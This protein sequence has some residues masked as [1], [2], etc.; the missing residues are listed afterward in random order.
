MKIRPIVTVYLSSKVP[1]GSNIGEIAFEL[2]SKLAKNY[3]IYFGGRTVGCM[4]KL[5]EGAL[6]ENGII[7]GVVPNKLRLPEAEPFPCIYIDDDIS[8]EGHPLLKRKQRMFSIADAYIACSGGLGTLD[9]LSEV[10][11][12]HQLKYLTDQPIVLLN[13]DG[14][15]NHTIAHLKLCIEQGLMPVNPFETYLSIANTPLE[16]IE[17]LDAHFENC[18]MILEEI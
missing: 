6:S 5:A 18:S 9:E 3:D 2:G 14:F 10:L 8:E 11:A 1:E 17:I 15:W 4:G 13:T 12:L 7:T 16:C